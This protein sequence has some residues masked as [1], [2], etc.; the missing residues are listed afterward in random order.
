MMFTGTEPL[1]SVVIAVYN[2]AIYLEETLES[3]IGQTMKNFEVILVNDNSKDATPEIIDRYVAKDERFIRVDNI[4]ANK[5]FVNSLNL[6]LSKVRGKFI[7]RLDGDDVCLP[8]RFEMQ[9][10][11]LEQHPEIDVLATWSEFFNEHGADCGYW[12][13]DRKIITP[14]QIR[15]RMIYQNCISHPTLM[16]KSEVFIKLQYTFSKYDHE[17]HIMWLRVLSAGYVL[18]KLPAVCLKYRIHQS[19]VTKVNL[20]KWNYFTARFLSKWNFLNLQWKARKFGWFEFQVMLCSLP[21]AV[22][23]LAKNLKQ[24]WKHALHPATN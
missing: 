17:D 21:D 12:E 4:P 24:R 19:S 20:K 11:Y 1:V 7:A 14:S 23:A 5:G 9:V 15:R 3:L 2:A 8:K 6:G 10:A 16:G 18:G 22:M 13:L